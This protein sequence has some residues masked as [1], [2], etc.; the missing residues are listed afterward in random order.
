MFR[1]VLILFVGVSFFLGACEYSAPTPVPTNM[2]AL[3]QLPPTKTPWPAAPTSDPDSETISTAAPTPRGGCQDRAVFVEDVTMPDN[4]RLDP[5]DAFVKTWKVRNDGNCAWTD[6]YSL[7]FFSGDQMGSPSSVPLSST[8][9]GEEIEISV[10]MVAPDKDGVYTGNFKLYNS[11]EQVIK[12]GVVDL[13]YVK[14]L[15]GEAEAVDGTQTPSAGTITP[16]VSC[17][18][19]ENNAYLREILNLINSA[20]TSNGLPTLTVN[21][22]LED[23]AQAHAIDMACNNF[24]SHTGTD[25]SS[26]SSRIAAQ[27]YSAS[28]VVENIF[29]GGTA[30]EAFNWWMND[31]PHREAIL[32]RK[33]TEVGIGYVYCSDSE[34]GGYFTVDFASP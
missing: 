18:Y 21:A 3:P 24:L 29:A 13:I 26:V 34:Y 27:G 32:D 19:S 4:T 30:A 1:R 33:V 8:A 31:Q 2:P 10:D 14:I 17:D 16:V 6:E 28:Y 5:G 20:R 12:I 22:Q 23:A 15:V 11:Q 9:P 25:G 7:V